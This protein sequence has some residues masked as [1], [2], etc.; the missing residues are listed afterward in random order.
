MSLAAQNFILNTIGGQY[1]ERWPTLEKELFFGRR[2]L[3]YLDRIQLATF[4]FGNMRCVHSLF[5]FALGL[6]V[7][8]YASCM[9]VSDV[10]LNVIV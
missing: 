6:S 4:K 10:D 7:C 8:L 1:V 9:R 2:E 3:S 5:V